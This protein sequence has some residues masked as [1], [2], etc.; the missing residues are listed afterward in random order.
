MYQVWLLLLDIN[1]GC[2][3]NVALAPLLVCG[4]LDANST[5]TPV[6]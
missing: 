5:N 4:A 3:S 1:A 2:S 6:Q